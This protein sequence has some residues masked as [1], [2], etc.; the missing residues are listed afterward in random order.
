MERLLEEIFTLQDHYWSVNNKE[1]EALLAQFP[2]DLDWKGLLRLHHLLCMEA[3]DTSTGGLSQTKTPSSPS[4][5]I[6]LLLN[7]TTNKLL[8]DKSPYRPRYCEIEFDILT[9]QKH[10][11]RISGVLM[12]ASLTHLGSIEVIRINPELHPVSIDFIPLERV[13]S[14]MNNTKGALVTYT[15]KK[16]KD[17]CYLASHYFYSSACH[18]FINREQTD[19][20]YIL[21]QD[22]HNYLPG[23]GLGVQEFMINGE[24]TH[25]EYTHIK[26]NIVLKR[27]PDEYEEYEYS[28]KVI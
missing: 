14:I 10:F 25:K 18:Q 6:R 19:Y 5:E 8:H 16:E 11:K 26:K 15:D 22:N 9:R 2:E 3:L 4:W 24:G 20:I 13:H 21:K 28:E 23:I 7:K 17:I 27:I 1:K 12:N